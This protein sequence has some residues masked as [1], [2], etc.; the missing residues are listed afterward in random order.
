MSE[1]YEIVILAKVRCVCG[2]ILKLPSDTPTQCACGGV[3]Y[4][5]I[6]S[7]GQWQPHITV[8]DHTYLK[9]L[10]FNRPKIMGYET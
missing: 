7:T 6:N 1:T 5:D 8:P 2:R 4:V 10:K 3:A 9:G